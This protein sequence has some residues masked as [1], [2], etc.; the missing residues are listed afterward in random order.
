MRVFPTDLPI[1]SAKTRYEG[2]KALSETDFTEDLKSY[3]R[4]DAGDAR[5]V[6]LGKIG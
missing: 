1:L 2:V 3:R 4:A 5:R 6:H